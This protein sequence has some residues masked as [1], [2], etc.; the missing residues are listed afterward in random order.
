LLQG[1]D[2]AKGLRRERERREQILDLR[3]ARAVYTFTYRAPAPERADRI[4]RALDL[5]RIVIAGSTVGAARAEREQRR[6]ERAPR[7][8]SVLSRLHG[9]SPGFA[10]S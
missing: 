1:A 4:E 8:Q 9:F 7:D 5:I 6:A 2:R 10:A 3:A